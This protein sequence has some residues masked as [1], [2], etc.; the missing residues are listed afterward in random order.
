M[1]ACDFDCFYLYIKK[2]KLGISGKKVDW[3]F[4]KGFLGKRLDPRIT[5]ALQ[6]FYTKYLSHHFSE[7]DFQIFFIENLIISETFLENFFK[8][9]SDTV[10]NYDVESLIKQDEETILKISQKTCQ[11]SLETYF[12]INTNGE[13]LA[14]YFYDN[15]MVSMFFMAKY[16]RFFKS[17]D[18]ESDEHKRFVTLM[19]I[20]KKVLDS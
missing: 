11:K 15:K 14:K 2:L 1:N 10:K 9:S 16:S 8:W 5:K 17:G 4:C 13:S 6:P 20:L 3:S 7:K 18:N 12:N 19:K